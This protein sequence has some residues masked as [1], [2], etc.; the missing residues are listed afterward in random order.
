MRTLDHGDTLHLRISPGG[1]KVCLLCCATYCTFFNSLSTDTVIFRKDGSGTI[2]NRYYCCFGPCLCAE[3]RN[4]SRVNWVDI[5]V[6]VRRSNKSSRMALTPFVIEESSGQKFHWKGTCGGQQLD[7]SGFRLHAAV[8]RVKSFYSS[9]GVVFTQP[10]PPGGLFGPSAFGHL[11]TTDAAGIPLSQMNNM[12]PQPV[13]RTDPFASLSEVERNIAH[14]RMSADKGTLAVQILKHFQQAGPEGSFY[15]IN[16][17]RDVSGDFSANTISQQTAERA[18]AKLTSDKDE[19][20]NPK[21]NVICVPWG[22]INSVL[23]ENLEIFLLE[24]KI[25]LMR[26]AGWNVSSQ[27]EHLE[28]VR[29]RN[30]RISRAIAQRQKSGMAL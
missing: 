28:S 5:D 11:L 2:K 9:H 12:Q 4:F 18:V 21:T 27:V 7:G 22:S 1:C 29:Q 8:E 6:N 25:E 13:A 16:Y 10:S 17:E 3:T 30:Q 19:I 26:E 23:E 20:Y 14:A 15:T 24:A